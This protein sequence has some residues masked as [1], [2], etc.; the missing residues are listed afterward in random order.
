MFPDTLSPF[1]KTVSFHSSEKQDMNLQR[2][3]LLLLLSG[4]VSIETMSIPA[5]MIMM[6]SVEHS[7]ERQ[8]ARETKLFGKI[9]PWWHSGHRK[10]Q[11]I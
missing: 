6:V 2:C 3:C 9:L 10:W 1:N 5:R 8:L 11:T 7:V 4:L